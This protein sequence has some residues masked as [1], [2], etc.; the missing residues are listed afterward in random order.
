M[1]ITKLPRSGLGDGAVTSA[2]VSDG[3]INAG[4]EFTDC[5]VASDRLADCAV[6]NAKLSNS[7][8]TIRGTSTS[9]GGSLT[10]NPD[11][12]WQAKITSDGSTVTTMVAGRGYFVDNSSAAGLV[13]LPASASI[14]DTIAIKDYAGNF[15][16]NNLTVQRNSH[17]IQGIAGDS[18]I[19][20][21]RAS[22]VLVYVDSTKGWLYVNQHNVADLQNATYISATGGTVTTSGNDKI[23]TFTGDGCFV[24]ASV[25]NSAGGGDKVSYLVVAG[26][27]SG[28]GAGGA[29]GGA[30][31]FREGKDAPISSYTASPL[32]APAGLTVS[33]SPGTYPVTI[34]GGAAGGSS[35]PAPAPDKQGH[36]GSNSVFSTITSAG[37]GGGGKGGDHAPGDRANGLNGG[38]GG[39]AAQNSGP[40]PRATVGSGN[41]PPVSP[42]QGNNGGQGN[43]A[44][45]TPGSGGGGGAATAGSSSTGSGNAGA[46][47]AG[48]TTSITGSSL[49]YAGGGGATACAIHGVSHG[50]GAAGP[51]GGGAGA[52]G[53]GTGGAGT[54]NRGGGGGAGGSPGFCGGSSNAGGAGGS[55]VVVIRYKF[56]GS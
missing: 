46:G 24:V 36:T 40:P 29:G 38:S 42:S 48:V 26:G 22:L 54:T 50:Q 32:N 19:S 1:A 45:N 6:T 28:A 10:V 56:Q 25:G 44:S 30:G 7:A 31:G 21:N 35:H 41:T 3:V 5:T 16:T 51:N 2:K 11:V 52:S 37:G 23:H 4:T 13:K 49:G 14:G 33:A 17:N 15:G 20:N 8:I 12:N 18:T 43:Y 53:N 34:G 55:G 39:G 9:L 47:G 27:G